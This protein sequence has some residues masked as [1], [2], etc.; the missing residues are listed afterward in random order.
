[1]FE[2]SNKMRFED[3]YGGGIYIR[4]KVLFNVWNIN[5]ITYIETPVSI[6]NTSESGLNQYDVGYIGAFTYINGKPNNRYLY[7]PT[8]I[9]AK[10]I[11]RFCMISQGCQIGAAAHPTN[12]ITASAVFSN[13]NYWCDNY[14]K[15]PQENVSKWLDFITPMYSDSIAKP[16]PEIGNDVWIGAGVTIVNGV[17]IGDGAIVAAGAVVTKDVKP[18]E[19][20][21]GVP[22]KHIKYRF[23]KKTIE[24]LVNIKWWEYG[25]DIMTG[26][27]LYD[28]SKAL[29]EIEA[30]VQAGFPKYDV[31]IFEFDWNANAVFKK[32]NDERIFY[33]HIDQL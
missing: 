22:A 18:Y 29:D 27:N 12:A 28:T 16:L 21:G 9:D 33:S 17:K 4:D 15:E 32:N 20:V 8:N 14:Y 13:G 3:K 7:R 10:G 24:R 6:G 25:V 1:M 30:R 31:E 26:V 11:G 2:L 5:K 19:I 23:D